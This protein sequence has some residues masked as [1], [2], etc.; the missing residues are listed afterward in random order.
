MFAVYG[1]PYIYWVFTDPGSHEFWFNK[2]AGHLQ[3]VVAVAPLLLLG[4]LLLLV[5]RFDVRS[6]E[7]KLLLVTAL[8]FVIAAMGS[9]KDGGS[10]AQ[11]V[12]VLFLATIPAAIF[13]CRART[14]PVWSDMRLSIATFLMLFYSIV[15]TEA[16]DMRK[17]VRPKRL[18]RQQQAALLQ[19]VR[20]V[21]GKT[22]VSTWPHID[23]WTRG[24][25]NA[26]IL[27]QDNEFAKPAAEN[28]IRNREFSLIAITPELDTSLEKL[29]REHYIHCVSLPIRHFRARLFMPTE[30]WVRSA[31]ERELALRALDH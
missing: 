24:K 7:G 21:P 8:T 5:N 6:A 26:S 27:L 19:I 29:V 2:A 13:V 15:M 4:P 20:S 11:Y 30:V 3:E 1:Q 18:D 23:L 16:N 28:A 25:M 17:Q 9:G 12:I 31:D 22:W 10:A 14:S